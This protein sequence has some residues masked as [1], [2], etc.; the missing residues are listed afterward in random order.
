MPGRGICS[1][2]FLQILLIVPSPSIVVTTDGDCL[3]C[4][5][6]SLSKPVRLGNFEFI[7]D[8]FNGLSLYP[9]MGDKGAALMG[10]TCNGES[11]PWWAMIEDSTEEFLMASCEE[12]SFG[13]PSP[14]RCSMGASLTPVITTPWLKDILNIASNTLIFTK[15]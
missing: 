11:T 8:Y 6:F 2:L 15:E 5:G 9:S 7:A 1:V 14:R 12:G 13:L 10:S 4:S 3:M